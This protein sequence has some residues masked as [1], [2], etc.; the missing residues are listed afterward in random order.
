MTTERSVLRSLWIS[1]STHDVWLCLCVILLLKLLSPESDVWWLCVCVILL[2]FVIM[3]IAFCL[4]RFVIL[5]D[6]ED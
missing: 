4:A 1:A 3:A 6:E 2:R 5:D